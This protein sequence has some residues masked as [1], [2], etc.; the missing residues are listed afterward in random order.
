MCDLETTHLYIARR[1]HLIV[2]VFQFCIAFQSVQVRDKKLFVRV[3]VLDGSPGKVERLGGNFS[4][5]TRQG[6]ILV[7]R[8]EISETCDAVLGKYRLVGLHQVRVSESEVMSLK[9]CIT[10][11]SS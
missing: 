11:N 2:F 6:V 8:L 4:D 10:K 9:V 7:V 5:V 3:G 1:P